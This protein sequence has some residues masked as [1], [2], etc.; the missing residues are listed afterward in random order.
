MDV[1]YTALA[2][3]ETITETI[4]EVLTEICGNSWEQNSIQYENTTGLF[5]VEWVCELQDTE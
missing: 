3:R 4:E 5:H 1:F 2:D